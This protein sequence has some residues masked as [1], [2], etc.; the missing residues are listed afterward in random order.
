MQTTRTAD[1]MA[2][3]AAEMQYRATWELREMLDEVVRAL[4]IATKQMAQAATVSDATWYADRQQTARRLDEKATE[5]RAAITARTA[6]PASTTTTTPAPT[7][8]QS[9]EGQRNARAELA[10]RSLRYL[11]GKPGDATMEQ[12]S[13]PS[14]SQ[15]DVV[16]IVTHDLAH[17][18]YHCD[19]LA[20]QHERECVH[21]RAAM[22][23]VNQRRIDWE[24][25]Q[26]TS[27]GYND[28]LNLHYGVQPTS[29]W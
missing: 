3:T 1:S 11:G 8:R 13:V 15:V 21:A 17:D 27:T 28:T 16:Y 23:A 9:R 4:E 10:Y 18:R 20:G 7:R 5:L 25:D 22:R 29:E 24:R 26:R 14:T 6:A 2:T 12:W 19:C